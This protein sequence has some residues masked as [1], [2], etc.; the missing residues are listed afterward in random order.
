MPKLK[1]LEIERFAIHDGPGIRTTVFLQGC[2][3]RC[4][5]C[6]NPESQEIA[7]HLMYK[8]D[9]CLRC[10]GCVSVC[11]KQALKIENDRV[12]IDRLLCDS[13]KKCEEACPTQSIRFVQT[14]LSVEEIVTELA[15]DED[16]YKTSNG[17]I[18]ISGGEA[19]V[20]FDGFLS[21]I[22]ACKEKGYHVAVETSGQISTEKLLEAEPYIDT[23][24]WDIKHVDTDV[25]KKVTLGDLNLIM[26]NLS[27]IDS[28]KVILRMP[29]IPNFNSDEKTILAVLE[30]A[31]KNNIQRVDLLPY[32][33]L[34]LNKYRQLD[35]PY[36]LEGEALHPSEL[37]KYLEYQTEYGIKISIGG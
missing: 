2:P 16:Y 13:C 8:Q 27:L 29:V 33:R 17:G 30:L 11:P 7:N 24:L 14:T 4:P 3:L 9:S 36:T 6:A 35:L 10:G 18:T 25:L 31:Y 26:E 5:W 23:F 37:E 1:V 28:G 21:L 20:Q 19:F 12:V 32:H 15:K 34:G 22:K